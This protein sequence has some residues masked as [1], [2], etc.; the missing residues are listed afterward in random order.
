MAGGGSRCDGT[1]APAVPAEAQQEQGQQQDER[2]HLRAVLSDVCAEIVDLCAQLMALQASALAPS[3]A[4]AVYGERPARTAWCD[5]RA[6]LPG[7]H[8]SMLSQPQPQPQPLPQQQRRGVSTGEPVGDAANGSAESATR[9]PTAAAGQAMAAP[10]EA[11][12]T[13]RNREVASALVAKFDLW[14]LLGRALAY[15]CSALSGL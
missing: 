7:G 10:A 11:T 2:G 12:N 14:T 9:A 3:S 15:H 8:A 6:V 4:A 1:W 13:A 5:L